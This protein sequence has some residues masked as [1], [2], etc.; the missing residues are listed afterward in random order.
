M[1]NLK[2]NYWVNIGLT[3][4]FFICFLTGLVKWP[5]LI[6]IIGTSAYKVLY[7]KNISLLHDRSGLIMGLLVLVHLVLNWGWMVGVTKSI[8]KRS[9]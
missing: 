5:G 9:I 8:F 7:F 6:T 3:I 1:S 2:L 4:S